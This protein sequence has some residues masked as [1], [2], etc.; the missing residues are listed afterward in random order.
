M[1]FALLFGG[2]ELRHSK[3]ECLHF[4]RHAFARGYTAVIDL[5]AVLLCGRHSE[6]TPAEWPA[7]GWC[8]KTFLWKQAIANMSVVWLIVELAER[9]ATYVADQR[10]A[11]AIMF[12]LDKP[13]LF[14]Q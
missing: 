9:R 3:R 2:V 13:S 4:L 14:L 6:N 10:C 5:N 11:E 7:C 12:R 8:K 1:V